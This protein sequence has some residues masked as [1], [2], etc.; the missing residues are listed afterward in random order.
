MQQSAAS[1]QPTT[2]AAN[3]SE[4]SGLSGPDTQVQ[5]VTLAANRSE[6][7]GLSGPDPQVQPVTLA[8]NRSELS[9][10]SEHVSRD[11]QGA[12]DQQA[13]ADPALRSRQCSSF[14]PGV[15]EP[16][17]WTKDGTIEPALPGKVW[18]DMFDTLETLGQH[19][20]N[21]ISELGC[22]LILLSCSLGLFTD[23]CIPSEDVVTANL[24]AEGV[25]IGVHE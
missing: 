16:V 15:S 9:G 8:A 4:P 1:S 14:D 12:M 20:Q 10:L 22:K 3:R 23:V 7:S 21:R 11:S 13:A 24:C 19:A 18:G 6:L 5:P 25:D 2:L 17:T